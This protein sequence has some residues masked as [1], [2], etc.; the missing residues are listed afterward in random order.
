M[1]E[2]IKLMETKFMHVNTSVFTALPLLLISLT[3][4]TLGFHINI[5]KI[6]Y[7]YKILVL[8]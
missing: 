6:L 2:I 3:L 7:I 5:V 1:Q 8:F 4:I